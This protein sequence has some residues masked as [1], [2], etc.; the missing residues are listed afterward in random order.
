MSRRRP[1]FTSRLVALMSS[2]DVLGSPLEQLRMMAGR[3]TS[4]A[5]SPGSRSLLPD[6]KL[7]PFFPPCCSYLY[8][9]L[10]GPHLLVR[11]RSPLVPQTIECCLAQLAL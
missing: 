7:M 9:F 5:R 1:A 10:N 6:R 11:H 3:K 8:V 4:A 2:G